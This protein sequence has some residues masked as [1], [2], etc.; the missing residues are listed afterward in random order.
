MPSI[1]D[2]KFFAVVGISTSSHKIDLVK[3]WGTKA[4]ILET[5]WIVAD[6]PNGAQMEGYGALSIQDF[7][8]ALPPVDQTFL[9]SDYIVDSIEWS[10]VGA[11]A[12]WSGHTFKKYD[13]YDLDVVC[14]CSGLF[15]EAD[16]PMG[17][18]LRIA[19][20]I[21][22]ASKEEIIALAARQGLNME[23]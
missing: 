11:N 7:G 16:I 22:R 10:E 6:F 23:V 21:M 18:Y 20:I 2:V 14:P 19:Y 3:Q 15:F 9:T 13:H 5:Q 8:S 12:A 4:R 1:I 17:M